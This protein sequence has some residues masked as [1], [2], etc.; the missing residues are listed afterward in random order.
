[1]AYLY[2]KATGWMVARRAFRRGYRMADD[3]CEVCGSP[4]CRKPPHHEQ[5][6]EGECPSHAC[7]G[8]H[9]KGVPTGE[10]RERW[11]GMSLCAE[12]REAVTSYTTTETYRCPECGKEWPVMV[13]SRQK[14]E[15]Y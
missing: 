10:K 8:K 7:C 6:R 11:N 12:R 15:K 4:L 13:D 2:C 1:M 5:S 14:V 9:V 3:R